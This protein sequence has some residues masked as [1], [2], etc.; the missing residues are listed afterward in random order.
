MVVCLGALP[1]ADLD[2]LLLQA[3]AT[4]WAAGPLAKGPSLC[5]GTAGNGYALLVLYRRM[6]DPVWL[7]RARAFAMHAVGQ[8]RQ[9]AAYYGQ[10]RHSLWTGDLG[11]AV[12][13]HDC[14]R[15]DAAF[16]TL[17]VFYPPR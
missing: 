1:G 11:L 2:Q 3:G 6:G 9:A 4:I 5:H 8:A 14:L 13:L 17:E 12:F 10:W 15:A 16:P 7:A